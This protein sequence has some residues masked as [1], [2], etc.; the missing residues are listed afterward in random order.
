MIKQICS[1]WLQVYLSMYDLFQA[2]DAKGLIDTSCFLIVLDH[3]ECKMANHG[4]QQR[5]I[6]RHGSY[7]CTCVN[8]YRLNSDNKTCS[9]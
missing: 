1:F 2:P 5:C 9:G 6:N 8:G 4:C 3:D 7:A